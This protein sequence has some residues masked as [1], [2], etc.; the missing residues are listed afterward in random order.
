MISLHALNRVCLFNGEAVFFSEVFI[1][2][3]VVG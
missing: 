2:F 3:F 1:E